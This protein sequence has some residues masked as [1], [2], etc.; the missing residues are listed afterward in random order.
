[1]GR[2]S[3]RSYTHSQQ[4]ILSTHGSKV[5][6]HEAI[7]G[8]FSQALGDYGYLVRSPDL[9]EVVAIAKFIQE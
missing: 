9:D 1:V 6:H 5:S 3:N 7:S 8:V 2:K 4:E